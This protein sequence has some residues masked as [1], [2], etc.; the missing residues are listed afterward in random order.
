MAGGGEVTAVLRLR[1]TD[2]RGRVTRTHFIWVPPLVRRDG[3]A[4]ERIEIGPAAVA[5][6]GWLWD[7]LWRGPAGRVALVILVL[8][9]LVYAVFRV[10]P[11]ALAVTLFSPISSS[12]ILVSV[13][14][15]LSILACARRELYRVQ[16][17]MIAIGLCPSCTYALAELEEEADGYVTCPEC[18]AGWD[19]EPPRGAEVVV[20]RAAAVER[21]TQ[22]GQRTTEP[23]A[24][25][26]STGE[27]P[28]SNASDRSSDEASMMTSAR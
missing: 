12:I 11:F 5:I 25:T 22:S 24:I 4:G 27:P 20:V 17:Q 1:T 6:L 19:R 23:P 8:C 2:D 18:G 10:G 7:V 14:V 21:S 16:R 3:T 28:S 26:P 9:G 15:G 13:T